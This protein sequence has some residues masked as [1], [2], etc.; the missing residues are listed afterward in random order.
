MGVMNFTLHRGVPLAAGMKLRACEA[1]G[2]APQP[3]VTVKI[4][5]KLLDFLVAI[6]KNFKPD[7]M[8]P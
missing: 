8:V 4:C 7:K 1:C 2:K 6:I 3:V 5:M